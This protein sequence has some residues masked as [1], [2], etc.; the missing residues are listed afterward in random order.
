MGEGGAHRLLLRSI[1]FQRRDFKREYNDEVT[2][3]L[4]G[5]LCSGKHSQE[6]QSRVAWRQGPVEKHVDSGTVRLSLPP[7]T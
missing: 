4:I 5:L 6:L 1:R 7:F 3:I 2:L